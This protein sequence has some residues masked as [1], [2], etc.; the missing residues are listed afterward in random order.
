MSSTQINAILLILLS[1][2]ICI[3][4]EKLKEKDTEINYEDFAKKDLEM[5]SFSNKLHQ[6]HVISN[7]IKH[8]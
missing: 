8:R 4:T 7:L 6:T 1:L 2:Y 5:V 3:T